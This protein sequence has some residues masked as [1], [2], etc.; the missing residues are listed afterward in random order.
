[1]TMCSVKQLEQRVRTATH[2]ARI[3]LLHHGDKC[4]LR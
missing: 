3:A 1:V 2:C 4:A